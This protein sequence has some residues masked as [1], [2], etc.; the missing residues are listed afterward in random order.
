LTAQPLSEKYQYAQRHDFRTYSKGNMAMT[1]VSYYM[2][3]GQ[4]SRLRS[5]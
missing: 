1:R 4:W 2:Y 5:E 3:M